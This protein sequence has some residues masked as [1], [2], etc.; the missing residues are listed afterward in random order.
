MRI[1]IQNGI[2]TANEMDHLYSNNSLC[3]NDHQCNYHKAL[4]HCHNQKVLF[5]YSLTPS[6]IE[7]ILHQGDFQGKNTEFSSFSL[8]YRFLSKYRLYTISASRLGCIPFKS[9]PPV[10]Y[11][12]SFNKTKATKLILN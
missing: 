3:Y 5:A 8:T 2:H 10:L 9:Q 12:L 11:I 6:Y 1:D 4:N 7:L